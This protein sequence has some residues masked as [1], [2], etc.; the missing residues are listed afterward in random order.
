MLENQIDPIDLRILDELTSD[1]RIPLVQLAKKIKVSN[2]LVH[3]RIKKLKA[4]GVLKNA[5]YRLDSWKLGYQSSSY[6]Q[7]K[8]TNAK[9]H[10][11]VERELEKIP[12]IVE[13]INIAGRFAL[14]V[15]IYAKN[16]RHLRDVIYEKIQP[17]DG[18]EETNTIM[19]FETAFARNVP[20]RISDFSTHE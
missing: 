4:S 17:I 3:Q 5:T 1:A 7:I 10:R 19:S 9:F 13:C 14:I 6:T 18:V 2:S 15:K 16:N 8:L 20:L 12:E 11:R